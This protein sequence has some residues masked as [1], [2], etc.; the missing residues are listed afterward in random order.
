MLVFK[1]DESELADDALETLKIKAK[2]N[3]TSVNENTKVLIE[4]VKPRWQFW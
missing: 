3:K 2:P 1:H 4:R